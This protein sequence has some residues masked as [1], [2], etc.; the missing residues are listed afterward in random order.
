M[1]EETATRGVQGVGLFEDEH[2][3]VICGARCMHVCVCVFM[4]LF[5]DEHMCGAQC[6]CVR[7]C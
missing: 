4:G 3:S 2:R 6:V 7:M 1:S 5:E